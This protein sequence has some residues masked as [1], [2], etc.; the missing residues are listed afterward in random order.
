MT[1][2][3]TLADAQAASADDSAMSRVLGDARYGQ[4]IDRHAATS[5]TV[6]NSATYANSTQLS[7]NL[8]VGTWYFESFEIVATSSPAASGVR[9]YL[10]FTGTGSFTGSVFAGEVGLAEPTGAMLSWVANDP[11][12]AQVAPAKSMIVSRIGRVVV[13]VAGT[14]RVQFAQASPVAGHSA[15]LRQGSFLRAYRY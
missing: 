8:D 7:I 1:G 6:T 15:Y 4:R 11:Q 9:S 14:L 3:L 12:T 13:S 2:K 5:Q 10:S